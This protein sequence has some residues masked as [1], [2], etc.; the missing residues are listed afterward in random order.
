MAE[1]NKNLIIITRGNIGG[2]Q[3]SVFYLAK[4]LKLENSEV[5]VGFGGGEWLRNKLEESK[6]SFHLF[7]RLARGANPFKNFFFIFEIKKFLDDNF[8]SNVYINSSNALAGALGAKLSESKPRVAFIFH[9]LSVIDPNYK[10]NLIIKIIYWFYFKFFLLFVDEPIFVCQSNLEI[11]RKLFLVKKAVVLRNEISPEDIRFFT[12][13]DS[14]KII[15]DKIHENLENKFLIGSIGRL[16]YAKNYEFL[17]NIFPEILKFKNNAVGLIIGEGKERKKYEELIVK[18][19]LKEKFFLVG[20]IK[21]A[22]N[23]LKA[24]DIFVL[25]SRYEGLSFTLLEA[26]AAGIPIIASDVGGNKEAIGEAGIVYRFDD[27]DEFLN[28]IKKLFHN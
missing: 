3:K 9:G 17:I 21:D 11:A 19:G 22:E 26:K 18:N 4:K 20:E 7:A 28:A 5:T 10:A 14:K 24:F 27:K 13:E 25:P 6:I 12:K 2:A 1:G 23:L 8:F 16:D 15:C